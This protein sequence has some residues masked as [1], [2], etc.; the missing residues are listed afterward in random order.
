MSS[1]SE[2]LAKKIAANNGV[3][4]ADNGECDPQCWAVFKI[5]NKYFGHEHHVVAYSFDQYASYAL[6]HQVT[7]IL[8]AKDQ[9]RIDTFNAELRECDL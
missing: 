2:S 6:D 8:W 5:K 4:V 1:M 9:Q 7:E 3:Y